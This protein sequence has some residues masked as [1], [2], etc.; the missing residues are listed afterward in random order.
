MAEGYNFQF[1]DLEEYFVD[2][3]DGNMDP[4]VKEAFEE[5]LF[6]NPDASVQIADLLRVR[7]QLCTLGARCQCAAPEGFQNRLYSRLREHIACDFIPA[8]SAFSQVTPGLTVVARSMS[9]VLVFIALGM[10]IAP[11]DSDEKDSGIDFVDPYFLEQSSPVLHA[12]M[13]NM[14]SEPSIEIP[15]KEAAKPLPQYVTTSS[16]PATFVDF[17]PVYNMS[18]E[19]ASFTLA[20]SS[21]Y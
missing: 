20:S 3:V 19:Q 21:S 17:A 16:S 10:C 12:M 15:T 11:H 9:L 4:K 7:T 5:F 18:V 1:S 6:A 2:Y 8:T 13:S 14:L